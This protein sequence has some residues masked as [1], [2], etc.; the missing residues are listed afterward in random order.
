MGTV[1][2][3]NFTPNPLNNISL[4]TEYYDDP[5]GQRTGVATSYYD[6]GIGLQHWLSPQIEMRPEF[7]AY[8]SDKPSFNLGN[9]KFER[10]FSGDLIWHF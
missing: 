3:W 5:E 8:W 6:V 10:V 2:Y 4:R 9:A 1:A 7:T